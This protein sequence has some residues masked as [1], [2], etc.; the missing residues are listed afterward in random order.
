MMYNKTPT[1]VKSLDNAEKSESS[2]NSENTSESETESTVNANNA[3]GNT[4][5]TSPV[6]RSSNT[7]SKLKKAVQDGS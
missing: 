7:D 4:T 6:K 2:V 1:I 3:L 5:P